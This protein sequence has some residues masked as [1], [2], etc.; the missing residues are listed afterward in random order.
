[1]TAKD[2]SKLLKAGFTIIRARNQHVVSHEF[3]RSIYAKTPA[4]QDWHKIEK[5]FESAAA[6]ER[7]MKALLEHDT[8]VED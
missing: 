5:G 8:I 6:L 1:M 3:E 4:K 2:Q 7:R